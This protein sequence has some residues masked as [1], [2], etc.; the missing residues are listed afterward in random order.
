MAR[1]KTAH[2]RREVPLAG[3]SAPDWVVD[4][5]EYHRKTGLYRAEDLDR[6]LGD[7]RD[8]V[9]GQSS[10]DLLLACRLPDETKD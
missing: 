8:Q 7:P 2:D 6:I 5:Q 9:G 10:N 3:P 1:T 4:M